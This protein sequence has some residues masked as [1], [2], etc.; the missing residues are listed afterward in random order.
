[1]LQIRSVIGMLCLGL[2][3]IKEGLYA[4][5]GCWGGGRVFCHHGRGHGKCE[6]CE[7]WGGISVNTV[8][9]QMGIAL[10]K[11]RVMLNMRLAA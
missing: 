1:M 6:G 5:G 8:E 10:K 3:Q 9:C 4:Y 7:R 2:V 11:L